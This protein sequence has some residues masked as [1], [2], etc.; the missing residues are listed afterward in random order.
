[1]RKP[2][3]A[4][5]FER[6]MLGNSSRFSDQFKFFGI[7][8]LRQQNTLPHEQ[9]KAGRNVFHTRVGG[10]EP[11]RRLGL[12]I[13][14]KDAGVFS[15]SFIK[16][17]PAIRKKPRKS[18]VDLVI[19]FGHRF[20]FTTGGSD[21]KE[22]TGTRQADGRKENDV[23]RIPCATSGARRCVTYRLIGS[24]IDIDSLEFILS[25]KPDRSAVRRPKRSARAVRVRND[26]GGKRIKVSNPKLYLTGRVPS[27]E[28]HEF[29]IRRH[30]DASRA[31]DV[32]VDRRI[33][34]RLFRR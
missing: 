16:K 34:G 22:W 3:P 8:L 6:Y 18:M 28:H 30:H 4:S 33:E 27:V 10:Q 13:T 29:A 9:Q 12:Q 2:R 23:L 7:E 19:K 20:W 24:A 1:S 15:T 32:C 26:S 21:A 31:P 5:T 11:T 17:M 25:E 14:Y